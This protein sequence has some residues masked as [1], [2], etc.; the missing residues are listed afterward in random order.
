MNN[1]PTSTSIYDAK[2]KSMRLSLLLI[3]IFS[4]INLLSI[5]FA[6]TYFLFSAYLPQILAIEGYALYLETE[7]AAFPIIMGLIGFVTV[8]PYFVCWIFSKKH[9]GWMIGAL[10]MFSLDTLLFLPDF[11]MYLLGGDFSML[12]DLVFHV[13]AL[14]SLAMGVSYG[15]KVKKESANLAEAIP[16]MADVLAESGTDYAP[17]STPKADDVQRTVTVTRKKSFVGCAMPIVIYVN[18]KEVCRLKNGESQTFTVGSNAFELGAQMS[19]GLCVGSTMVSEGT[20]AL[21]YQ[22]AIKSGM[23]TS[24]IELTQMPT[25]E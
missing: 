1:P 12:L 20:T 9:I 15:L 24:H 7:L 21:S 14:V 22:A 19:N 6:E 17:A 11:L 23:M 2:Y 5:V 25:L 3:A 18:G 8:I 4:T 16:T 13:Y 10:V